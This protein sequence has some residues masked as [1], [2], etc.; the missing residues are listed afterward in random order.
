MAHAFVDAVAA[1]GADAVKF[2]THIADAESTPAEPWRVPFSVQD[3]SRYDYWRRME[4]T[5]DQ[6]RGLARHAEDRGLLFLSSPFSLEAVGLLERIGMRAWKVPSGEVPNLELVDRVAATRS[7]VLL[8]SGMSPLAEIDAAVRKVRSRKAPVAVLQCASVYPCPPEAVGLN[9]LSILRD[10]Y[11]CIVG[12][13]DHSGSVFPALAAV[14]LGAAVVEVHV[15]LSNEMFGPDVVASVTTM[16]LRHLAEGVRYIERILA[17]PVDKDVAAAGMG[18]LREAF[19]KSI[20]AAADLGAGAV[21]SADFLAAKKPGSGIAASRLPEFV[22][23]RLRRSV[24]AG[25][26]LAEDDVEPEG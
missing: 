17:N 6:W 18:D 11:S 21:L 13:S 5:E 22:G 24:A 2:Q 4:F 1:A 20:V 8:S 14:A 3:R 16:E 7:P 19:T 10:R 9:M 23:R 15:T 25:Q 12:L 26:L